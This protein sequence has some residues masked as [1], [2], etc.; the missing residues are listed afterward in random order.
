MKELVYISHPSSG[1]IENTKHIE[2]IVNAL[3]E[4][5]FIYE[6]YC[7]VSPVHNFGFMYETTDY[8]RGLQYCL[9]LMEHCDLVMLFGDYEHSK[10]CTKELQTCIETDTEYY[11]I[12]NDIDR[13]KEILHTR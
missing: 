10:G 9:D 5:D 12:G 3:Y 13:A 11:K 7:I 1:K 2:E 6:N 4:D 8:V